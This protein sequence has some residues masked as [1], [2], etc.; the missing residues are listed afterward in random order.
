VLLLGV[1]FWFG[2]LTVGLLRISGVL[3]PAYCAAVGSLRKF[4]D[5]KYAEVLAARRAAKQK[6]PTAEE[7][8]KSYPKWW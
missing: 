3:I 7:S 8:L 4:L 2:W 5:P 6:A 1:V